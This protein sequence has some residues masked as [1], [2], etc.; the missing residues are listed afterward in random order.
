MNARI[1]Y[2]GRTYRWEGNII[3]D[4]RETVFGGDLIDLIWDGI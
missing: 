4:F 2:V 1:S 3:V